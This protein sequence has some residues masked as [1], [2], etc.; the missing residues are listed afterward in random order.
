MSNY[1]NNLKAKREASG[2]SQVSLAATAGVS[3]ATISR[4][5]CSCVPVNTGT[6]FKLAV[7][8]AVSVGDLFPYFLGTPTVR[9]NKLVSIGRTVRL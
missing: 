4:L 9:V 2:L 3:V 1:Q 7:A 5:E 8:L 6:A